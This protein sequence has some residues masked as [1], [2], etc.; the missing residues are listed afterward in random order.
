V[1]ALEGSSS[2]VFVRLEQELFLPL[3]SL[4]LS[5][6]SRGRMFPCSLLFLFC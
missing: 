4:F 3:F 6:E 1:A 5:A 2:S